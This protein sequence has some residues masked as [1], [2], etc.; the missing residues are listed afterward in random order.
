MI[1][2]EA[3]V[4]G[5]FCSWLE[6][7]GWTVRREVKFVDVVAERGEEHLFAEAKGRTSAVGLDVDTL[8]GQLLRR[9]P[10]ETRTARY[11]VVVPTSGCVSG[12]GSTCS[13]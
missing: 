10:D 6:R 1:G 11:A 12:S 8:H 13:R 7:E 2:D 3:R 5:A 9:M 4:V